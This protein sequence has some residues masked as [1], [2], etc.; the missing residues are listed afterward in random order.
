MRYAELGNNQPGQSRDC[1]DGRNNL[2]RERRERER[3]GERGG[4]GEGNGRQR[5]GGERR[6]S[7]ILYHMPKTLTPTSS[8]H[9]QPCFRLLVLQGLVQ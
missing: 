3:E 8:I 9:I 4:E 2:K 1:F 7:N 5:E 6:N